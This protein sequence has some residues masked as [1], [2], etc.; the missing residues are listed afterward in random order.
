MNREIVFVRTGRF[1]VVDSIDDEVLAALPPILTFSS[2]VFLRGKERSEAIRRGGSPVYTLENECFQHDHK[3]RITTNY[4][5]AWAMRNALKKM[6]YEVL[7]KWDEGVRQ[8]RRNVFEPRWQ[9]LEGFEFRHRQREFLEAVVKYDIGQFDC[10]T[11]FGKSTL[12]RECARLLPEAKIDVISFDVSV[13]RDRLYSDL[14]TALPSVGI[15]GGGKKLFGHRVMCYTAS[16][17]KHANGDADIVFFDE[18]HRA[19][20]PGVARDLGRYELARMFGLSGSLDM[21]GDNADMRVR[22]IFGPVRM[23]VGYEEG[24]AHALVS[25][26][27]VIW[28][29]IAGR[30]PCG[31]ESDDVRKKRYGYWTNPV[32]NHLI[33]ED[34]LSY[35]PEVQTMISVEAFEHALH[36]KQFLPDFTLIYGE[37]LAET[38]RY[39]HSLKDRYESRGLWPA[40]EPVMSKERKS[41]LLRKAS[42]GQL[43]KFIAT[44]VIREGVDL[45][46]LKVVLRADGG[47]SRIA[48]N[49]IPGR[50][51]RIHV[52]KEEGIIHD[53][54][55]E[56]DD[57]YER[58][59]MARAQA[60]AA[61][62]WKQEGTFSL[63]RRKG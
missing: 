48:A 62:H 40:G 35:G 5:H 15:C 6:G 31:D 54:W 51:S 9:N 12:I 27:R 46:E 39:G 14:R 30:N 45:P 53:Y 1:V 19:G 55:D 42:L 59:S 16:S 32:R 58:H 8:P 43:K 47:R 2:K 60:Y 25:P 11:G 26:I 44:R 34:A 57:L 23:K 33:A 50:A 28:R 3:G 24:V 4:G 63:E 18:C 21:R 61:N 17:L 49:Q 36:L 41:V 52:S 7:M 13:L 56:F 22:G 37:G 20:A 29:S 38:V 10:C